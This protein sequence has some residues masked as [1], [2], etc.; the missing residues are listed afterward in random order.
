[1]MRTLLISPYTQPCF[2]QTPP[3]RHRSA[4]LKMVPIFKKGKKDNPDNYRSVSLTIVLG[5][6]MEKVIL[7]V[8]E[9]H[10]R[11]NEVVGHS[12]H[13]FTRGSPG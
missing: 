5:K 12:Q 9:K 13:K 6:I 3:K 1:M 2:A 4:A 7:G 11:D 8:T 10:W